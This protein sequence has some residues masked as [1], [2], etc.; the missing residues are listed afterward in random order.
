MENYEIPKIYILHI[1][2]GLGKY[3]SINKDE[4]H[5]GGCISIIVLRP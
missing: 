4:V 1:T 2:V 3:E 5:L